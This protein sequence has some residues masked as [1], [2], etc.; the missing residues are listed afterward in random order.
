MG[1]W[2]W[3][4][5]SCK[6]TSHERTGQE[7]QDVYS[8]FAVA[9]E[10]ASTL[11]VVVADGAGS[12]KFGR[13]GAALVC[14]TLG[15]AARRHVSQEPQLPSQ[16]LFEDWVDETRDRIY[17]A[18]QLRGGEARD[19]ASTLVCAISTGNASVFAH[20]GDGCA[21]VRSSATRQWFAPTWPDQG[22]YASTTSFV[23]DQPSAKVR[24]STLSQAID[25]IVVF[26]DGLERMVLDMTARKPFE[27]FFEGI[28]QPVIGSSIREGRDAKLS[29]QLETYLD[30][31][32]VNART[33]DDKTLLIAAVL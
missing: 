19:F 2:V 6:G 33:D 31:D 15:V 10:S 20:V 7:R 23:T 16:T 28:A 13:Q 17:R 9:K 5:A 32:A 11:V 14:R 1:R 27:P 25:S 30:S 3:A 4:A 24:V 21:V 18:A 29:A 12:A 26:S 8:C 22:E